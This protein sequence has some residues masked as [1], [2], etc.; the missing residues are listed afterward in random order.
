MTG[1]EEFAYARGELSAEQIQSEISQFW[2]ILDNQD[3]AALEAELRAAGLDRAAL[4][5]IDRENAIIVRAR[6]SG[7]DT[8]MAVIL[9]TVAPSVNRVIKDLWKDILL[10]R[11]RRRWGEDAIGEEKRGED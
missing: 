10:P 4:A 6:R 3:S 7:V 8:T 2:Q 9:V 11:I 5:S 1:E